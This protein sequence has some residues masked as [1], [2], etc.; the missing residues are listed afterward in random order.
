MKAAHE[1]VAHDARLRLEVARGDV[2]ALGVGERLV[3]VVEV[4]ADGAQPDGQL[5]RRREMLVRHLLLRLFVHT[6]RARRPV[7]KD[8]DR[9]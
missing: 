5:A 8:V 2:C 1:R 6:V 7:S 9:L 3:G 4:A